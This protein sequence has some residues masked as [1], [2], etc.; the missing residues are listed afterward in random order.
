MISKR[1]CLR[2]EKK[3]LLLL[4]L[5]LLLLPSFSPTRDYTQ[6]ENGDQCDRER[7]RERERAFPLRSFFSA[8]DDLDNKRRHD[9]FKIFPF[10]FDF[11]ETRHLKKML[12]TLNI[13]IK[14]KKRTLLHSPPL[15]LY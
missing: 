1:V 13:E 8:A 10:F 2:E 5:L 11:E 9:C 4:L 3:R 15:T 6:K 14:E 7:E 12:K